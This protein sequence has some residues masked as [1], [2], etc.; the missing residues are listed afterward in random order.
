MSG[1][2][3]AESRISSHDGPRRRPEIG[4]IR[5]GEATARCGDPPSLAL[6]Q[7]IAEFNRGQF[8][9]QHETLEEAWIEETDPVR[10][11]YQGILQIG[12]GFY[13]LGRGNRRGAAGMW[14]KG[15]RLLEDFPPVCCGV[16]VAALVTATRHCMAALEHVGPDHGVAGFDRSLIPTIRLVGRGAP[17]RRRR[18]FKVHR[19]TVCLAGGGEGR[20]PRPTFT[21]RSV[22]EGRAA[23]ALPPPEAVERATWDV[24]PAP[25]RASWRSPSRWRSPGRPRWARVEGRPSPRDLRAA[26]VNNPDEAMGAGQPRPVRRVQQEALCST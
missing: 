5:R 12:V 7:G 17:P 6:L 11:L 16:D 26:V 3:P 14:A 4:K 25:A 22:D 1:S 13:H 23:P 2:E 24:E 9:E 18:G 15:V 19:S 21:G 8:F 20:L 10:Y